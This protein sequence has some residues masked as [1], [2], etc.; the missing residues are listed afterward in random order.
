MKE[1]LFARLRSCFSRKAGAPATPVPTSTPAPDH[2]AGVPASARVLG[3]ELLRI[4]LRQLGWEEA[5]ATITER[6]IAPHR[7]LVESLPFRVYVY[8]V[9]SYFSEMDFRAMLN[10]NRPAG[11]VFDAFETGIDGVRCGFYVYTLQSAPDDELLQHLWM[12]LRR[13]AGRPVTSA[14]LPEIHKR[15]HIESVALTGHPDEIAADLIRPHLP[16]TLLDEIVLTDNESLP[17]LL[18][19]LITRMGRASIEK[20]EMI[21][22][23]ERNR[24]HQLAEAVDFLRIATDAAGKIDDERT[25]A[26]FAYVRENLEFAVSGEHARMDMRSDRLFWLIYALSTQFESGAIQWKAAVALL[27]R[28]ETAQR[29]SEH[30]LVYMVK[31]WADAIGSPQQMSVILPMLVAECALI[32]GFDAPLRIAARIV[33]RYP[34]TQHR[35]ET[36]D[37]LE[38]A[39]VHLNASS[40]E[41]AAELAAAASSLKTKSGRVGDDDF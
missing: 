40:P 27:Q 38:R 6:V 31:D 36:V 15:H 11:T 30:Q 24:A 4:V 17:R 21:R 34:M 22:F 35:A 3:H 8:A 20:D 29:I 10:S 2:D 16:A 37:L 5:V 41:E 12:K 18:A 9:G 23:V 26:Y 14:E 39:A 25:A 7:V 13:A 33:G 1:G 19:V 28:P 32:G